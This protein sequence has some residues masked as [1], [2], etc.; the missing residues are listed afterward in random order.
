MKHIKEF[1]VLWRE[2]CEAPAEK[3]PLFHKGKI[4]NVFAL[5]WQYTVC[6]E[7]LKAEQ[8][9]KSYALKDRIFLKNKK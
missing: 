3:I 1:L 5:F 9:R 7:K 2:P 8:S 6:I 4:F